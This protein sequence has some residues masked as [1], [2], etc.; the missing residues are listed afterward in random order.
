M[1]PDP[2]IP[3]S[4][5]EHH[6]Y[7]TDG[8]RT[9]LLAMYD[10]YRAEEVE[11]PVLGRRVGRWMLPTVQATLLARFLRDDLPVYPPFLASS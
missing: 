10:D 4:A 3:L 1:T 5:L 7:F 2:V 6:L 8:G 11:H 9:T